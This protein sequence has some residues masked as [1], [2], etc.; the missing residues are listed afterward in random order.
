MQQED[1]P[2]RPPLAWLLAFLVVG[3]AAGAASGAIVALVVDGGSGNS[4]DRSA[5]AT[6]TTRENRVV[7]QEQSAVTD[8]VAAVSPEVV[9]IINEENPT[10]DAQGNTVQSVS[11][12]SGWIYDE[13]G[14]I[15]TNEHVIDN[16][17][18]LQVMLNSGEQRPATIVSND[19]PF[20]DLAVIRI[21][22]G[23]LKALSVGDSD[24]LLLGQTVIAIGSALFEY[25][26]SVSVG[27]ISGLHRRWLRDNVYMEDLLQTDA[28]INNGNS[29]GPIVTT[30]GEVVGMATNV[31]RHLGTAD[32][33]FGISF[34]ISSNTMKPIVQ[35]IVSRGQYPR[36]YFGIDHLDLDPDV[37]QQNRV[38]VTRGAL[39][40]R[41]FD[42][43]PAQQAGLKVGDVILR[44]GNNDLN[45]DMPFIN[46]LSHL[47]PNDKVPVQF[48]RAGQTQQVDVALT[49]RAA[50]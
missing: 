40:R 20:T 34:A 19:A 48:V 49:P 30:K 11:V 42:G 5:S 21:P 46:A 8:A 27:V 7:V 37:A 4:S 44:I 26:N 12:G 9:T 36:P 38:S 15:V 23:G 1:R 47:G 16:A 17:G 24:S 50:P 41:V 2:S 6:P 18:T 43:S 13:R 33:V 22:P 28:A 32:T 45:S 29:G 3:L 14:F 25:K 35:A 39:V 31:V 10:Q